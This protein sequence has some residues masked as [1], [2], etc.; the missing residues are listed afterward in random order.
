MKTKEK[1]TKLIDDLHNKV[2]N[3]YNSDE[4]AKYLQFALKFRNRSE[5]NKLLIWFYGGEDTV[6]VM[7][8][9]QWIQKMNRI[10]VACTVCRAVAN[11]SE[12]GIIEIS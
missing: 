3:F 1:I 2:D 9:K 6:Y 11:K 5:F 4:W 12:S 7:G 8:Y 10:V